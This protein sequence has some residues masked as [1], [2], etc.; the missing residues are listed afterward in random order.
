MNKKLFILSAIATSLIALFFI[1]IN[2]KTS[3]NEVDISQELKKVKEGLSINQ[4]L[5]VFNSK[6]PF[7]F[8]D[9]MFRI[10]SVSNQQAYGILSY[11]DSET[12]NLPLVVGVAGSKGWSDHHYKY[13]DKYLESGFATFTLHSFKSRNVSS[14]VGEQI[15]ATTAMLVYDSFKALEKLH[16]K[17]RINSK[18]IG[19]TGYQ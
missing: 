14:T 15:S 4:E 13:M 9:L 8:N 7:N 2:Y 5:I 12:K 18:N 3:Y 19:I 17:P 1:L 10:N 16:E 11:P 6:N